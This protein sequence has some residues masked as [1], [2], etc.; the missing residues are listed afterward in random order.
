MQPTAF[1]SHTFNQLS[2]FS[3]SNTK[4]GHP[5]YEA[6]TRELQR[7]L[8]EQAQNFELEK[9]ELQK[10][11]EKEKRVIEVRLVHEKKVLE[12]SVQAMT[13]EIAKLKHERNEIRKN[14]KVEIDKLRAQLEHGGYFGTHSSK[15]SPSN[16][17]KVHKSH[18]SVSVMSHEE[19]HS[20]EKVVDELKEKVSA[21]L[22]ATVIT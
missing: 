20:F 5:K 21:G 1:S 22:H 14:Y 10:R 16:T 3:D 8:K 19:R 4:L 18:T 13:R 9:Q 12:I 15:N 2:T 7:R 11:Y 17:R 6:E